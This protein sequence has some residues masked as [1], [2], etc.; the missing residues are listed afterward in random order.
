MQWVNAAVPQF[1]ADLA[2]AAQSL[3]NTCVGVSS[4]WSVLNA[5][6]KAAYTKYSRWFGL[7]REILENL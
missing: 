5:V 6:G 2:A 1:H 4:L 3:A 7:Q